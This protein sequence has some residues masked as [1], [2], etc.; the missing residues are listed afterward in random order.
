MVAIRDELLRRETGYA[1]VL[2]FAAFAADLRRGLGAMMP[3]RWGRQAART[4]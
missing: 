3:T 4:G 2:W 1:A